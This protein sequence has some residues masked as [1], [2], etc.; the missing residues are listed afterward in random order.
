M[1]MIPITI[2]VDKDFF[3]KDQVDIIVKPKDVFEDLE[4][5]FKSMYDSYSIIDKKSFRKEMED[6]IF[7]IDK[8]NI[9][10]ED[11][12]AVFFSIINKYMENE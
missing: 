3:G 1:R 2:D 9:I 10:L 4:C 5:F 6:F 7:S 12:T 8:D 11:L